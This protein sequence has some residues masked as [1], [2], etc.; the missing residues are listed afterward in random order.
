VRITTGAESRAIRGELD[1]RFA[2]AKRISI[3]EKE[4][5]EHVGSDSVVLHDLCRSAAIHKAVFNLALARLMERGPLD[6]ADQARAAYETWRRADADLREVARSLGLKRTEAPAPTLA[7]YLEQKAGER[8]R[9]PLRI[10]DAV[11]AE[12]ISE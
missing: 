10:G 8:K 7:E 1:Q 2:F 5:R 11:D 6:D 12:E 4:Y 3:Y 9:L